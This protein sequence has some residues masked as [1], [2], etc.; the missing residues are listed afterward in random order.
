V[1]DSDQTDV[2]IFLG[3]PIPIEEY[4]AWRD[5]QE[6]ERARRA[7]VEPEGE[8]REVR[9]L[10]GSGDIHELMAQQDAREQL[11]RESEDDD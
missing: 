1:S 5:A 10:V 3:A 4:P 6:R 11:E 9:F 7:S 8:R 2:R